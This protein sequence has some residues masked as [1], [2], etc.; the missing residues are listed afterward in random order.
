MPLKQSIQVFIAYSRSD[1]SYLEELRKHL[2]P[3]ERNGKISVWTDSNIEPGH[4]WDDAI[5]SQN[6]QAG[7]ILLLISAD[8]LASDYFS[9][10]EV[11]LAIG[12]HEKGEAVVVPVILK[13]CLWKETPLAA[14]QALPKD[15]KPIANWD[16][17]DDAWEFIAQSVNQM[18]EKIR[19]NKQQQEDRQKDQ[20]RADERARQKKQQEQKWRRL[21]VVFRYGLLAPNNLRWAGVGFA[22]VLLFFIFR[23]M[24]LNDLYFWKDPEPDTNTHSFM[25][26]LPAA[27]TSARP[28]TTKRVPVKTVSRAL[29]KEQPAKTTEQINPGKDSAALALKE[30][31]SPFT[32]SPTKTTPS[33][34]PE[35]GSGGGPGIGNSTVLGSGLSN[36][37]MVSRPKMVDN[38]QKIGRVVVEV[39]VDGQ[40]N[41]VSADYT[42]RGSTTTDSELRSKAISWAR[43]YKFEPSSIEKQCGTLTFNFQLK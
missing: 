12:R 31:Q 10:E 6:N 36:R 19:L 13:R 11:R 20:V 9:G 38:T 14:I 43:Q 30:K 7:I 26:E 23:N 27:D 3:L 25:I 16:S 40:G 33:T 8:S 37:K 2:I 34:I 39:C 17:R 1:Q 22:A 32:Q 18:V 28:D 35:G 24:T 41:V 21:W 5:K 42:F 29:Q 15:G 4:R